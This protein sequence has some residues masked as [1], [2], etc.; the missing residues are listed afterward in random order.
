MYQKFSLIYD[1]LFI[2]VRPPS[3]LRLRNYRW[4]NTDEKGIGGG[5]IPQT[6]EDIELKDRRTHG[7][8]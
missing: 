2:S 8:D 5:N 7:H 1:H 4:R 6:E 3:G